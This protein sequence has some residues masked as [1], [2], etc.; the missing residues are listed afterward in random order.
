M[1]SEM[2][3]DFLL[4]STGV[5]VQ[6]TQKVCVRA[7]A[8]HRM[9]CMTSFRELPSKAQKIIFSVLAGDW[10]LGLGFLFD[11]TSVFSLAA[12]PVVRSLIAVSFHLVDAVT[13]ESYT[14][15]RC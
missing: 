13:T 2:K 4:L 5:S 1:H 9:L 15:Q 3:V 11:E 12:A 7:I 8:G 10:A 14:S 6:V